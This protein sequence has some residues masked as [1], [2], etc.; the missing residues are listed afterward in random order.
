MF[1]RRAAAEGKTVTVKVDE[2]MLAPRQAADLA[3][4]SRM[5]IQRR[6]EDGTIKAVKRGSHWR[7]P[8]S[9]IDRFRHDMMV[10][11]ARVMVNDW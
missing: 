1:V 10:E 6:V 7:I 11:T 4:V 2:R 8:E 5:T 9:E 3:D